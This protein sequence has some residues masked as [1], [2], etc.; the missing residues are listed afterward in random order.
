M[1]ATAAIKTS[2]LLLLLLLLRFKSRDHSA[3][4]G[5]LAAWDNGEGNPGAVYDRAPQLQWR[6]Y[7]PNPP[8]RLFHKTGTRRRVQFAA[9][10]NKMRV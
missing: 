4:S 8:T 7:Q 6:T 2:R 9:I 3:D 5:V 1:T 10:R